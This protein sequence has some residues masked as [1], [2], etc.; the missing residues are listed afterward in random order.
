MRAHT[1]SLN[2]L[3]PLL[4]QNYHSVKKRNHLTIGFSPSLT[5]AQLL[6]PRTQQN[7]RRDLEDSLPSPSRPHPGITL[8]NIRDLGC[9]SAQ[10]GR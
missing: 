4:L 2:T 6:S 7:P 1:Y 3:P 5:R 10:E 9:P 8:R